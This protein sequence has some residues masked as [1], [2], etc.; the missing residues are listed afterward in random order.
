MS[1]RWLQILELDVTHVDYH[2]LDYIFEHLCGTFD[3]CCEPT[4]GQFT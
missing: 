4:I 1:S 3:F 2:V